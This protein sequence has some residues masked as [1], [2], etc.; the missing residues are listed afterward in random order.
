MPVASGPA[1]SGLS[2]L[3]GLVGA[4]G[5]RLGGP[6]TVQQNT[7]ATNDLGADGYTWAQ[8]TPLVVDEYGKLLAWAQKYAAGSPRHTLVVSGDNGATW[9]EPSHTGFGPT[10]NTAEWLL[11]RAAMAYDATN[12]LLHVCWVLSQANGSVIYRQYSFTRDGANNITGVTRVRSLQMEVG[13]SGMGFDFPVAL[14][15]ADVGKLLIGWTASNGAAAGTTKAEV[16]LTMRVVANAASD[17]VLANWVAP[18]NENAGAGSTDSLGSTGLGKYSCIAKTVNSGNPP[19]LALLRKP[20]SAA[21]HAKDL[22]FVY[23]EGPNSGSVYVNRA[24]WSAANADWRTGLASALANDAGLTTITGISRAGSDTGYSLK[25]QLVS[26]L[27]YDPTNDALWVGFGT[28][29]DNTDGDTWSIASINA[30]DAATLIDVY[31]AGAANTDGARDIFVTGDVSYDATSGLIVVAYTDLLRHD[32]YL[33]TYQNG[34]AVQTGFVAY[35]A[36]PCD[37]PTL[38]DTRINGKLALLFRDFNAGARSNPPTYT[39]PYTGYYVTVAL[40]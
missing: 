6:T 27:A 1:L 8:G 33:A 3:S 31:K 5:P 24:T 12:H 19:C 32:V 11:G 29:K 23:A 2:G 37:I 21:S 7:T 10:D 9:S 34:A 14:W 22:V 30:S 40:N 26:K 13:V 18:L 20:A 35:S 15:C 28:W 36:T 4:G 16:R 17:A 39:P 25:Y 38:Y